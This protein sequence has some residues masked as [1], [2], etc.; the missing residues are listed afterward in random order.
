MDHIV[1]EPEYMKAEPI[2]PIGVSAKLVGVCP[3][4]LRMYEES[5]LIIPHKTS[6]NMRLF[7][8]NDI[9]WV[10]FLRDLIKRE[11]I[12]IEAIRRIL[13]IIPC[14]KI[15]KCKPP[16]RNDCLAYRNSTSPCWDLQE[17]NGPCKGYECGECVVYGMKYQ[18]FNTKEML[19]EY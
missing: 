5:G 2:L 17:V 15:K 1:T 9:E 6:T 13:A 16:E 8:Q 3:S 14:W 7:S 18:A 11:K 12:S 4:T 10:R 19:S